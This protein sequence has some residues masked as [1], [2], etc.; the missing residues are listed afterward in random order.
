MC[1]AFL[2]IVYCVVYPFATLWRFSRGYRQDIDLRI[3]TTTNGMLHQE[4]TTSWQID[5]NRKKKGQTWLADEVCI[6]LKKQTEIE[7]VFLERGTWQ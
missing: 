6:K 5:K 4:D 2:T 1:N 3:L 7:R